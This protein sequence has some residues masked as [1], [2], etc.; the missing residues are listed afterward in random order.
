MQIFSMYYCLK[1]NI[2]FACAIVKSSYIEQKFVYLR[3]LQHTTVCQCSGR[4][5]FLSYICVKYD[6]NS[7]KQKEHCTPFMYRKGSENGEINLI[8]S[9][10]ILKSVKRKNNI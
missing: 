10:F 2:N 6:L 7:H 5:Q 9:N 3:V 1:I 8:E 4:V